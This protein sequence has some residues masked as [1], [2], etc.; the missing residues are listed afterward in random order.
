[1]KEVLSQ[2]QIK[3]RTSTHV[4]PYEFQEFIDTNYNNLTMDS[5]EIL[6]EIQSYDRTPM[7]YRKEDFE[8]L[9]SYIYVNP[10]TYTTE[11]IQIFKDFFETHGL[12]HIMIFDYEDY[13]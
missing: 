3:S 5:K 10:S 8:D 12:D 6:E 11:I 1:M 2:N 4:L 13:G 7:E 9:N